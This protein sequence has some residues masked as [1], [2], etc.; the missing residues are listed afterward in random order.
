M[1]DTRSGDLAPAGAIDAQGL[2]QRVQA[3]AARLD[4]AQVR[5][6]EAVQTEGEAERL[7]TVAKANA[8][9]GAE[10]K[11]AADRNAVTDKIVAAERE[12]AHVAAG[13]TK[14]G[15]EEVRNLRQVLSAL[16][17]VASLQKAQDWKANP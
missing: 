17:S 1:T 15:L 9:L 11:T 13:M 6:R 2:A 7:Y 8:Y 5:L 14:A 3:L 12:R 10:G 4:E 16:Q